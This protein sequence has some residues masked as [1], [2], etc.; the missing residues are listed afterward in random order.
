MN[1]DRE[2]MMLISQNNR[3]ATMVS[4][5]E[6]KAMALHCWVTNDMLEE[7][8]AVCVEAQ[9]QE[10]SLA[11]ESLITWLDN[12]IARTKPPQPIQDNSK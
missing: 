6:I 1:T 8:R 5:R 11:P 7:L 10:F 9:A 2:H 4:L 12:N 3:V